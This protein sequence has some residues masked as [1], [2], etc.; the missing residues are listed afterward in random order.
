MSRFHPIPVASVRHDTREAIV[1]TLAVPEALRDQYRY[2]QG[3]H[4]TLRAQIDGEEMRRTYS[5]CSAVQDETL[6][7]AIKC[8]PAGVF[9]PWAHATLAP[10]YVVD[11]LPPSG[12][13]NVPLSAEQRRHYVAFA[14][15]S[16]ITP[17]FGIIK[18]TLRAEPQSR[19]TLVYG[20]RS[21]S[22]VILRE[23]LADL[24]DSY[25]DRLNLVFVM[26]REPQE[27]DLFNGRIDRAKCDALLDKWIDPRT[28]D[29]A[30]V[31][32]PGT[33]IEDVTASLEAHGVRKEHIKSERFIANQTRRAYRSVPASSV[34]SAPGLC[35]VT[36]VQDGRRRQFTMARNS[37]SILD[38]GL[39]QGLELPYACKGGICSTCRCKVAEG[40]V[41]MNASVALEDYELARGFRLLCQSYPLSERLV[42]DYDQET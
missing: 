22:H 10:G 29:V 34:I 9:S 14:A 42:L 3:Q 23:E 33:M 1:V 21:S 24:K 12:R 20:N 18:T 16:G 19:V 40:E 27:I 35:E 6:R 32:G 38:A 7:V 13:F 15:G 36:I 30:F 26:S 41:D 5:I 25:R 28:I 37:T 17:V 8:V 2:V 39:A 31:C 11:V 4:V